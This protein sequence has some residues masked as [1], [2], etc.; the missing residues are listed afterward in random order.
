MFKVYP[1]AEH[2]IVVAGH[3]APRRLALSLDD[4]FRS[5]DP[6][7][8]LQAALVSAPVASLPATLQAPLQSQE[9]WAAGVTYFRSR[10]ARMEES[11]DAG[12][13]TFYDKVYHAA[14]PELFFK[15]TPS[16]VAA[17]GTPVRIRG[18]S[19]WNVPEPELTLAVNAQG[20]IFGYTI[21]NDMSSRDIEGENPL[22][23]P[24][25]KVYDRSAALGPCLYVSSTPLPPETEIVIEIRRGSAV[26]FGGSTRIDQIKRTFPELA[27]FLFRDNVFPAGAYLMTGTGIVP[28]DDFTLRSG[29]EVH[30]TIEPIGTLVNPIA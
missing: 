27:E 29:D 12:G 1:S 17:P 6:A 30:I 10:T 28:P 18:D 23:L 26:V 7:A 19:K 25:A 22:Y 20:R 8:M 16:R 14:R 2:L 21:G 24:Q 9:V 11:K 13:G 3:E 15:S 5:A 4:L